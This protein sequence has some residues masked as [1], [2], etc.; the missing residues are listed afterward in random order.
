MRNLIEP[1]GN[2]SLDNAIDLLIDKLRN[3]DTAS[4]AE[5]QLQGIR[6]ALACLHPEMRLTTHDVAEAINE[7]LGS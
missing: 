4:N 6:T 1:T 7:I 5:N 2:E 3:P